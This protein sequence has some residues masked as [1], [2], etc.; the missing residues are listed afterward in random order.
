[1]TPIVPPRVA[2]NQSLAMKF[3]LG[4]EYPAVTKQLEAI[5]FNRHTLKPFAYNPSIFRFGSRV[6]MSYR[7]HPQHDWK[8]KLMIAE[9]DESFRVTAN[10][11][12]S[13][14]G[15]ASQEDPHLFVHLDALWVSW[16]ESETLGGCVV[17]YGQLKD[18]KE[19]TV[20]NASQPNCG[21]QN[22]TPMEKNWVPNSEGVAFDWI[23]NSNQHWPWGTPKGGCIVGDVRFF[24]STLDNESNPAAIN[25]PV[26]RYYI[27]AMR[28]K[29]LS[30][31][32]ILYGSEASDLTG[33]EIRSCRHYKSNVV[34]CSGAIEM[35]D[36]SYVLSVGIND[37]QC[38]FIRVKENELNL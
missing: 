15:N 20:L 21:R 17:K 38:A 28:G 1:M 11:E 10:K 2:Y 37:S 3:G 35:P 25:N 12:I 36:G 30:S 13:L 8:T 33:T 14:P 4:A 23:Y 5:P 29:K 34:F 22:C 16:V 24:H 6:F 18:G 32:P 27:G 26:R 9:L 7:W 19:W 31:R